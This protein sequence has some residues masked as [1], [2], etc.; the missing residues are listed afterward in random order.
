MPFVFVLWLALLFGGSGPWDNSKVIG[1]K[2]GG[3]G[4]PP[5]KGPDQG[6]GILFKALDGG[7]GIPP[8]R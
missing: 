5:V 4:I 3:S 6:S 7:S 1:A 8:V 2:D